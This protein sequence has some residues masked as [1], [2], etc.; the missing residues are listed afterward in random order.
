MAIP[1]VVP[2]WGWYGLRSVPLDCIV[3][4][5]SQELVD[6]WCYRPPSPP[7]FVLAL[8]YS[9]HRSSASV[10][11]PVFRSALTEDINTGG[12]SIDGTT[13]DCFGWRKRNS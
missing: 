6:V 7:M 12:Q 1:H 4:F 3:V 8:T 9:A 5:A 10:L 2:W 11:R 13:L